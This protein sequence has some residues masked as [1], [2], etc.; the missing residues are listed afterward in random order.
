MNTKNLSSK[1]VCW[2]Q[3]L[4]YYHFQID[5]CQGKVNGAVD[6]LFWYPQRSIKEEQSLHSKNVKILHPL[7]F[8][9]ARISSLLASQLSQISLLHQVLICGTTVFPQ[10]RQFWDFFQ[11]KMAFESLYAN[12]GGMKLQF[13]KLQEN[14]EETKLLRDLQA[15]WRAGK[16]LKEC[17][18]TKG[19]YMSQILSAPGW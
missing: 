7:Q 5:Y 12:I 8:L 11:N 6:A 14:D 10:L 1:Q 15:F 19:S 16:K 2:A 13:S 4:S 3:K 9:L 17:S 18:S